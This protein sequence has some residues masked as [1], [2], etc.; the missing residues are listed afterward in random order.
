MRHELTPK[1]TLSI[2]THNNSGV[3]METLNSL[4]KYRPENLTDIYVIDNNS[5]DGTV[6]AL[7]GLSAKGLHIIESPTNLGFGAAHNLA[8]KQVESDYHIICNPDIRVDSDVFNGLANIAESDPQVGILVTQMR[9]IDGELQSSNQQLPTVLDLFLRRFWP[10]S[11]KWMVRKRLDWYEMKHLGYD[12]SYGV[13]SVCG[14]FI[15][16]RTSALKEIGGFDERFFLY[17]EDKDL[18]IRMRQAGYK[19]LYVPDVQVTHLWQRAA[20][21]NKKMLQ[22]HLVNAARYFNKWG[23]KLY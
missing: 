8:I 14:A 9:G 4:L 17:F 22:I 19:T 12:V 16:C 6:A 21:K 13:Q 10:K 3:V 7:K 1:I 15:F 23:W 20:Y 2:V 18:G 5:T 11:L